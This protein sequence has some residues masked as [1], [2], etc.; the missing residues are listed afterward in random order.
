VVISPG[1]DLVFSLL[2]K[3]LAGKKWPVLCRVDFKP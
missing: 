2:A 3:I 1:F